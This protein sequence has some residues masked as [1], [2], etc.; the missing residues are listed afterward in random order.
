MVQDRGLEE[1]DVFGL[2]RRERRGEHPG[3]IV[4]RV[5]LVRLLAPP[6][7]PP[8]SG[9]LLLV[10]ALAQD[11]RPPVVTEL[12]KQTDDADRIR[13]LV[14]E[15]PDE[16]QLRL[17]I[18]APLAQEVEQLPGFVETSVDIADHD[19]GEVGIHRVESIHC[20]LRACASVGMRLGS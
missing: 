6:L 16:H 10:V 1:G 9:V 14:D 18:Q 19:G 5:G 11:D 15:I 12:A 13:P 17:P 3:R 4:H 8:P 7:V 2:E 20:V